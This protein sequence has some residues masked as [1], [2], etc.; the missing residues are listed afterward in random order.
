MNEADEERIAMNSLADLFERDIA[1]IVT[2]PGHLRPEQG[3][4]PIVGQLR[5]AVRELR[6]RARKAPNE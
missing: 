5:S 1:E 2:D 3:P 4:L 6:K